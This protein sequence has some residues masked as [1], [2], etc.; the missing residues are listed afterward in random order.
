MNQDFRAIFDNEA[1]QS[2][3]AQTPPDI[4]AL[5]LVS[6][7]GWVRSQNA[8]AVE[9]FHLEDGDILGS[10]FSDEL[11]DL[12]Y[13]CA[14]SD[15]PQS[16]EE[17]CFGRLFRV[18]M[19]PQKG[20][21]LLALTPLPNVMPDGAYFACMDTFS[22]SIA[23]LHR[24]APSVT[25]PLASA[26]LRRETCRLQR[27]AFHL[28]EL[29]NPPIYGTMY[30]RT[31]DLSRLCADA[32]KQVVR[33][34]PENKRECI[35]LNVPIK[36]EAH[37]DILRFRAA[38]YNLLTNAVA[39]SPLPDSITFTLTVEERPAY[40]DE[41]IEWAVITISDRGSGLSDAKLE[42]ALTAWRTTLMPREQLHAANNRLYQGMG[43]AYAQLIAQ[44]HEG[45][46]TYE[47]RPEGGSIF[48]LA[49]PLFAP[50]V[51]GDEPSYHS[52][53]FAPLS[54]EDVE[55]SVME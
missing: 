14:E 54:V 50:D 21:V 38:V 9:L 49:V 36:C 31:C 34:L 53:Y 46:L 20:G 55:L 30:V 45:E 15:E 22:R 11:I 27:T 28:S 44:A 10:A 43:L 3:V 19:A 24:L 37:V 2:A 42:T 7:E 41:T 23:A 47:P 5:L 16:M 32:V 18:N 29:M 26:A 39:A 40:D 13:D 17:N 52:Y 33:R 51:G 48:R 6:A 1:F 8:T 4:T 35:A 25:D 12:V